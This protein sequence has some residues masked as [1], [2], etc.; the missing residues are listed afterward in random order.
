MMPIP[1]YF[2]P[3]ISDT[4]YHSHL[5]KDSIVAWMNAKTAS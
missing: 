1:R 4:L 5:H 3:D 2:S